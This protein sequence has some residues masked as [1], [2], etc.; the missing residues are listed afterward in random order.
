MAFPIYIYY[1]G[2]HYECHHHDILFKIKS[3]VLF[4][5]RILNTTAELQ[6]IK[7]NITEPKLNTVTQFRLQ[8]LMNHSVREVPA[9]T[10]YFFIHIR[11]MKIDKSDKLDKIVRGPKTLPFFCERRG[12]DKSIWGLTIKNKFI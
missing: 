1:N 5:L 6:Q 3:H 10:I 12:C 8:E 11:L 7:A 2:V 4:W 9:F